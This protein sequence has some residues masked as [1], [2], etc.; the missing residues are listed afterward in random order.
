MRTPI[1]VGEDV[2]NSLVFMVLIGIDV[3]VCGVGGYK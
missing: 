3:Q 2:V 1:L